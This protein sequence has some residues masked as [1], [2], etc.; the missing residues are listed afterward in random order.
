MSGA[1]RNSGQT[2]SNGSGAPTLPDRDPAPS[3]KSS[4]RFKQHRQLRVRRRCGRDEIVVE[5]H[6]P[7]VDAAQAADH[8]GA[9]P[10]KDGQVDRRVIGPADQL[11]RRLAARDFDVVDL[12]GASVEHP[13]V[14]SHHMM[15]RPRYERG[16]RV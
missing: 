7:V 9:L 5:P 15:S 6:P 13:D 2:G 16:T 10:S 4:S 1:S 12:V 3:E 11:E 8:A 14:S